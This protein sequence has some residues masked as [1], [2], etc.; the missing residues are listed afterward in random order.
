MVSVRKEVPHTNQSGYTR[1]IFG[2]PFYGLAGVAH[3]DMSKGRLRTTL[4]C[5]RQSLA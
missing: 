4:C 3:R 2:H 5:E 1:D